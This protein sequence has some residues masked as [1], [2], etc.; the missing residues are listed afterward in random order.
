MTIYR[1]QDE[2]IAVQPKKLGAL[3]Q[4]D[5]WCKH[6]WGWRS[7]S[8]ETCCRE[9]S[10]NAQGIWS[11]VSMSQRWNRKRIYLRGVKLVSLA[12]SP[13]FLYFCSVCASTLLDIVFH[14]PPSVSDTQTQISANTLTG[15][16]GIE[17]Y[18]F[19]RHLSV[20]AH[21]GPACCS[22]DLQ[23]P[24]LCSWS[25]CERFQTEPKSRFSYL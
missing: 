1:K 11:M 22:S 18:Q 21:G 3:E 23:K 19:S 8:L 9:S 7:R 17:L 24:L 16:P 20:Q 13:H 12:W 15:T 4:R 14:I 25:K 6:I 2:A 5:Q 10:F